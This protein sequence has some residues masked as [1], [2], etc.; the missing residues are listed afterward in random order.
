MKKVLCCFLLLAAS[1]RAVSTI[2]DAWTIPS[3]EIDPANYHGVTMANGM[4]GLMSA[5]APFRTQQVLINGTFET[6]RPG[7]SSAIVN[8]FNF[9]NI[10]FLIDGE[11]IE[12]LDQ[13]A[14]FR[15][16]LDMKGGALTTTFDY[17]D[18]ASVSS[19]LRALRHL[20]HTALLEISVTAK[21]AITLVPTGLIAPPDRKDSSDYPQ[22]LTDVVFYDRSLNSYHAERDA[23]NQKRIRAA[24]AKSQFGRHLIGAAHTFV[25]DDD[26]AT[27]PGATHTKEGI[28]FTKEIP[29]GTTWRFALIGST[30]SS[31]H[32]EDPLNEAQRLTIYAAFQGREKLVRG[33]E[34]AWADLW[35]SD[36]II[37][38][39]PETQRD[40]RNMLFHLYSS[41]REG[42]GY[43]ISPMG[44]SR[45]PSG[46]LGHIYWDADFWMFPVLVAL[47]PNL[48]KEM[49]EYR[50]D[51]LP[52]ARRRAMNHGYRG[53]L[54]PW[55]SAG[56]GDDDTPSSAI[57]GELQPH[58]SADVAMAA[59]N[60]YRVTKD[61]EWLRTKG[62]SLIK[63]TA[64]YWVSRVERNG[65]GRYDINH[66]V[67]ADE[68]A[69]DVDNNAFTNAAARENL[70][71]AT[72]TAKTLGLKPDPEWAH[73][74][75]NIPILRFPDGVVKEHAAYI[76]EKIKQAD[77]NLLAYPL[78]E[79]TD[80]AAILRDLDYYNARNDEKEGPAMTKSIF[81]ILYTR[82]GQGDKAYHMFQTGYHPNRRP[83]FGLL[84]ENAVGK[85]PY[86][87]TAAGGL[88]QALLYG[89]GGLDLTDDG[90]AR[91]SP[92]LP[93]VWKSITIT[94]AGIQADSAK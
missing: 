18:K 52:A 37:E 7:Y 81:A 93:S 91:K 36:I 50:F 80:P 33:H 77:V 39:D 74:R 88:L 10:A 45:S 42:T 9:L 34:Q 85:N 5:P 4:I 58:I 89:F 25:F 63:E 72:A 68:Y 82:Q 13:V 30:L 16:S 46:Y 65:P 64:D 86:F 17:Q 12:R 57:A 70:A 27:S 38:G 51:R 21:R 67:A 61:L 44:L 79:V 59:W 6:L 31:A 90:I 94:G 47:H 56:S 2:P 23:R 49:L 1:L 22:T 3:G 43:S 78:R 48:A 54:F 15:Q 66:V 55:E 24:S 73:V 19:T 28:T 75:E 32:V 14:N 20:P 87:V 26:V 41:I 29:A 92:V 83:P 69:E 40:V 60:Y 76:G 11:R 62:Y 71:L 84:A 35:K 53:A 8:G